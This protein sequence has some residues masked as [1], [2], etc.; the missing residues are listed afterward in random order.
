M[1][2]VPGNVCGGKIVGSP[3]LQMNGQGRVQVRGEGARRVGARDVAAAAGMQLADIDWLIPHQANVRILEA[4][5]RKLGLP[6]EKLVVTVDHHAQYVRG[7]G[8]A[9]ARRIR[10]RTGRSRRATRVLLQGVGGGFTWGASLVDDA[11]MKLAMVFPGQGS[12][13]VGMLQGLRRPARSRRGRAGGWRRRWATDFLRLLD[14]GPAEQLSLTV[15]TQPAMVTAGYRR[16]PRL[17]RARRRRRP[18]S[19]PG[20][21]SA[22]TRRWS[23]PA[24]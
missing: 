21:A 11:D 14:E 9:R 8:A 24:R 23:P 16:V 6:R 12:Q 13:A 2:S 10:A 15:N 17:A 18:R 7:L 5:A 19:S 1:L 3:F 22:N 4:T 20:T